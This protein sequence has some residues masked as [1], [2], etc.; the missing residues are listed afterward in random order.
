[1]RDSDIMVLSGKYG[2]SSDVVRE[3]IESYGLDRTERIIAT[4]RRPG[5]HYT[6]RANTLRILPEQLIDLLAKKGLEA[7]SD[8]EITEMISFPVKGPFDLPDAHKRIV[9]DKFRS[10]KRDVGCLSLRPRSNKNG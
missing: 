7:K 8:L 5:K 6:I 4:L 9:A 1:M 2:Y 3:L 10:R